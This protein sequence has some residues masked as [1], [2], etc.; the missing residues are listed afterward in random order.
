MGREGKRKT[1]KV[2]CLFLQVSTVPSSTIITLPRCSTTF[3]T[4]ISFFPV[5]L[6]VSRVGRY[7]LPDYP[8][9]CR[10]K[11]AYERSVVTSYV[12]AWQFSVAEEQTAIKVIKARYLGTTEWPPSPTQ[13]YVR[14]LSIGRWP[15]ARNTHKRPKY[16]GRRERVIVSVLL[17]S[18]VLSAISTLEKTE[19]LSYKS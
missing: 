16:V 11:L 6:Q 19:I 3:S 10:V 1:T 5:V 18:N 13:S 2:L 4:F 8:R 7:L 9:F 12:R 17:N 14:W 15:I